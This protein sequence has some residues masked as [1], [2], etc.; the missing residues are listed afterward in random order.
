MNIKSFTLNTLV[1]CS[2]GTLAACS[3]DSTTST[4]ETTTAISGSVFASNVNGAEVSVENSS[5]AVIAG[6]VTT[7]ADGSYSTDVPD[8]ALASD[9]FFRSSGGLFDDEATGAAGIGTAAGAMAAHIAGGSLSAGDSVHVTPGSTIHAGLVGDHA[10]DATAARTTFFQAFAYHPDTST[11]PVDVTTA[12]ALT[13]DDMSRVAGHHA[14]VMSQLTQNLGL[15]AADQFDLF[16][17]LAQDL[18]DDTLNGVDGSG[19]VAIGSTGTNLPADILAQYISTSASFTTLETASYEIEYSASGMT[20]HGKEKFTLTITNKSDGTGVT[21]LVGS[22]GLAVMPMMYMAEMMHSTPMYSIEEPDPIAQAGVYEVTLFYLMPSR[23][24]DTTMGTWSLKVMVN[25]ESAIFYPNVT[26]AM[27][28][29]VRVQLKG[30]DDTIIDMNGLEVGRT[31]NLFKNSLSTVPGGTNNDLFS[32]FIAPIETMMSFPPLVVPDTLE[33][34]M[35]GTPLDVDT[36]VVDVNVN[37]TGWGNALVTSNGGGVWDLS[38]L[39]LNDG[40]ENTIKVRLTVNGETKTTNG[41]AAEADVNDFATFTVT[42]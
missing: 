2:L 6:P 11:A 28:D 13:A 34:G 20:T 3:S 39:T 41:L 14:A 38:G 35:G 37:D 26:M 25:M 29:T 19:A 27:G 4:P 17:A 22:G 21:G 31:Y 40:V 42:P 23:M 12:D 30:I 32:V 18:S 8:S 1:A 10:K 24:M 33:S 9:L 16:A 7:V 36:V 15:A 5:G